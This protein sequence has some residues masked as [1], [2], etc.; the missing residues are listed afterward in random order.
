[1]NCTLLL[2][3][4]LLIC[5]KF[6]ANTDPSYF[7]TYLG[8]SFHA[9]LVNGVLASGVPFTDSS[10]TSIAS[11]GTHFFAQFS[12]WLGFKDFVK[13]CTFNVGAVE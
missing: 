7:G 6:K 8:R 13:P 1:M 12:P 3:W 2:A 5:A 10:L 4:I 9:C 11:E